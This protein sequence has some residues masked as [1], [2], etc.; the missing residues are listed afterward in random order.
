[1]KITVLVNNI[2]CNNP[3]VTEHEIEISEDMTLQDLLDSLDCS[4][5]DVSNYFEI[6]GVFAWNSS[7]CPYILTKQGIQYNLPYDKVKV[8][9]FINTH[10]IRNNTL[11]VTTGYPQAGGPGFIEAKEIWDA[12][13]PHLNNIAIFC[14]IFGVSISGIIT[15]IRSHFEKRKYRPILF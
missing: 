12:V 6:S 1:M 7:Y 15:S 5:A 11:R 14:T 13:Q 9:D 3:L 10:E 8:F 4:M 2:A